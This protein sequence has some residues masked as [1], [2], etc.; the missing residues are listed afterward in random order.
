MK[1]TDIHTHGIG[2][3]DARTT[4]AEHIIKIA[5]IQGSYGVSDILLTI[6][7]S[8]IQGMCKIKKGQVYTLD[9]R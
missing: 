9:N 5:D 4:T 2:G 6:Y 7:P 3:Y 1:I 8:S